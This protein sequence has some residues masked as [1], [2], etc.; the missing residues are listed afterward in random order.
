MD[1]QEIG[2]WIAGILSSAL[3]AAVGKWLGIK[4]DE[5]TTAKIRWALEQGVAYAFERYS[6]RNVSGAEKKAEALALAQSIEPKAMRKLDDE[7]KSK[8][9]DATYARMRAS[10]PH[11]SVHVA[12]GDSLDSQIERTSRS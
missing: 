2:L 9:V 10:L 3:V 7:Q 4:S 11:S 6:H 5:A 1:W 8:L 12:H